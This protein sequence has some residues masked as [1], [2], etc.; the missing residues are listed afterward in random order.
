MQFEAAGKVTL[1]LAGYDILF[2]S[3]QF[4]NS[5]S[6]VYLPEAVNNV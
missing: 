5:T 4:K 3:I 2:C 6:V 1:R